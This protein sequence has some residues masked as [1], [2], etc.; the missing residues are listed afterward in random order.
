MW[1]AIKN[2]HTGNARLANLALLHWGVAF[3]DRLR[4]RISRLVLA[5]FILAALVGCDV[6]VGCGGGGG[7]SGGGNPPPPPTVTSVNISC[8]SGVVQTGQTNQCAATVAGTGSYNSS[9]SWSVSGTTDGSSTVGTVSTGGLYTAPSSV[10]T[11]F[12]VSVT[13]TSTA[14]ATKSASFNVIVAGTI[15]TVTEPISSASGGTITLPDGSSVTI[16]AGA[17]PADQSVTLSEV[18]WLP[19]QPPNA[20]FIGVGPALELTFSTPILPPASAVLSARHD[21]NISPATAGSTISTAFSFSINVA[22]NKVSGL[23]GSVPFVDFVDSS[24]NNLY[25]GA[26][27]NYDSTV[28]VVN[29]GVGS[30]AWGIL[31][32][33]SNKI[34]GMTV[35]AFNLV[36]D[37]WKSITVPRQLSLAINSGDPTQDSWSLYKT[38][39]TGK[40]LL[41]VHGM[42]VDVEDGFITGSA[43]T[44][45]VIQP[46]LQVGGYDNV[47]GFD[48]DWTQGIDASG[49]QL[50]SFLNT[51]AQCPGISLDIEA[52]SEGVP[53][54]LSALIQMNQSERSVVKRVV[55]VGGPIM[56]TPMADD[57]RGIATILANA[58]TLTLPAGIVLNNLSDLLNRPFTSDLKVSSN[59]LSNIRTSLSG[60]SIKGEP[61]ILVVAG[62][63]QEANTTLL[64]WPMFWCGELMTLQGYPV[65]DGFIPLTSSLALQPGVNPGSE[66]EVYP[67]PP[68]P[69]DHLDL[70]SDSSVVTAV[71][72]QV[73]NAF[74]PPSLTLSATPACSD[75]L[76]CQ[77]PPGTVFALVG[78]GY[79]TTTAN[80]GYEL[81]GF[82]NIYEHDFSAPDGS[83][84]PGAWQ[85][86][87]LCS[88]MPASV[89]F[90]AEDPTTQQA[91]NAVTGE[92]TDAACVTPPVVTISPTTAQIPVNGVQQFTAL[93]SNTTNTAVTWNVNGVSG[94][95]ASVGTIGAN[96]LYTAP[97][98]VPNPATIT[99]AAI[100]QADTA[101]T[102]SATVT[103]GP[104]A[105]KDIDSFTSLSDGGAPSAPLIQAADTYFYSTAQEGGAYGYGTVFR[106][107]PLGNIK[108]L[109]DFTGADGANPNGPVIEANQELYGTTDYGGAYNKGTVFQIDPN[110]GTFTT[111][112]SFTGG[113]DGGD[114]ADG[115]IVASGDLYGT[116]FDG[117][118]YN[119]G[120][121]FKMSLS[122]QI[123]T[124]YSFTGG[125]DGSGPA[126]LILAS[127]GF[128]YG[129][130]QNGGDAACGDGGG[131]G[132]GT[133]FKIDG[134]GNLQVL[135]TFAGQ[136]GAQ[137]DE[138]LF[139][140]TVDHYLYGTTLF[141]GNPACNVS[142]YTGCGTIFRIDSSGTFTLL[143]AFTGGAEGGVPFSSLIQASD[144]DFY[145]TAGAGGDP[146]CSV[147]ASGENFPTYNGCGT[148]FKMDSSGNVNAL[149]SFK[150]SPTDGSNPFAALLVGTDGYFYGTTRWGGTSTTC[151]YT[152]NGGCGTFYRL[153]GPG[154]PLSQSSKPKAAG[155]VVS[156]STLPDSERSSLKQLSAHPNLD[157]RVPLQ[158]TAPLKGPRKPD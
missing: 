109:H 69:T 7:N 102:A 83:I 125:S 93:V 148:I 123:T 100:S 57:A 70:V 158:E 150:G 41:V 76:V 44:P 132:C 106:V 40:T 97:A 77:E 129:G 15:A 45:G 37:A 51:V 133:L 39:P 54:S 66:L 124:L 81:D 13:A 22:Q 4:S 75:D 103:I 142:T 67:L 30:D 43:K 10:P 122:G 16:A 71:G 134:S 73:N 47:L 118:A 82:G 119:S 91:S 12:T 17:L 3:M 98:A 49:V 152:S 21:S 94:G 80:H 50:A 35:G 38:C 126:G 23:N 139:Q 74:A 157:G 85:D 36:A 155:S 112:Y 64:G 127:D 128:F 130:T 131:T 26:T 42:I 117:G 72:Q 151:P 20:S 55:A 61:Q 156:L 11:P 14:D 104:Y 59:T 2:P 153:A 58:G 60:S 145:G 114:V 95:N 79:S 99:V 110:V 33:W 101:V 25:A 24:N 113:S 120:T 138:T 6:L 108:T 27:G 19:Q 121:V 52:H 48:Y 1:T 34:S 141:G 116:T 136:D 89:M 107:D 5:N 146:S 46:I 32:S 62:N 53:V 154:G 90:F 86:P 111:L 87:T 31:N 8:P 115:L 29:V 28:P 68:F 88:A 105:V 56:G 147:I 137:I 9:V 63:N 144:G 149:Y 140:S 135:H 92:T 65:S 78:S 18:S 143:H 84:G 96:G